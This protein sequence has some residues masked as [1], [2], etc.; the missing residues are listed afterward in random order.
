[1]KIF[2]FVGAKMANVGLQA[3]LQAAKLYAYP[4]Y[5]KSNRFWVHVLELTRSTLLCRFPA[6]VPSERPFAPALS[7]QRNGGNTASV[8]FS[9]RHTTS[10][11]KDSN[12][13][14]MMFPLEAMRVCGRQVCRI[15]PITHC[16]ASWTRSSVSSLILEDPKV[17]L[18]KSAV[19][20]AQ[21]K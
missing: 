16:Y 18:C 1:M 12:I 10:V 14:E 8:N 19:S 20:C 17:N 9:I 13:V 6:L 11:N 5:F 7:L 15:H 3:I 2:T 21:R 4:F